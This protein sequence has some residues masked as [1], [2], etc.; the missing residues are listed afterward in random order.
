MPK[1]KT[2]RRV[3]RRPDKRRSHRQ[4][5]KERLVRCG[6]G[7]HLHETTV[8]RPDLLIIDA[9]IALLTDDLRW[10]R[11]SV[12]LLADPRIDQELV[13]R[14]IGYNLEERVDRLRSFNAPL[15]GVVKLA[16]SWWREE[17]R[18]LELVIDVLGPNAQWLSGAN[19]LTEW[20]R[21]HQACRFTA[22]A[23]AIF[24]DLWLAGI[25]A[26]EVRHAQAG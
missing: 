23:I 26:D 14:I 25:S 21:R 3:A 24:V 19:P 22:L 5:S 12:A 17:P 16:R 9:Q 8:A 13:D 2:T 20:M 18:A 7:S 4:V 10:C 1:R 6:E 15:E 11:E